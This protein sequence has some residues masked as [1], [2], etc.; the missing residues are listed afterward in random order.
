MPTS[1]LKDACAMLTDA[2][3]M[4]VSV[5]YILCS[6]SECQLCCMKEMSRKS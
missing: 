1:H 2:L 5:F 3:S 6:G 4:M